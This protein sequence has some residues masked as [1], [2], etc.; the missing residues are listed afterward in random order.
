MRQ[1]ALPPEF[2]PEIGLNPGRG[3][4]NPASLPGRQETQ[5]N[6]KGPVT[7]HLVPRGGLGACHWLLSKVPLGPVAL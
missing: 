6:V 2:S 7:A 5:G 4:R 1:G 3:F